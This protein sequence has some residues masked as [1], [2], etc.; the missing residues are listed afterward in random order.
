M[1]MLAAIKRFPVFVREVRSELKK[2]SWSTRKELIAAT[3]VV[4]AGSLF[5]TVYIALVDIGLSKIMQVL[6]K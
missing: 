5:L 1:A 2:V 4:L 3:G 6:I